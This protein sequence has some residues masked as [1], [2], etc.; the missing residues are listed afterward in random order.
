MTKSASRGAHSPVRGH[1]SGSKVVPLNSWGRVSYT[2]PIAA[3][4][5]AHCVSQQQYADDTQLYIA[6]SPNDSSTSIVNLELCLNDLYYWC[7]LNGLALNPDKTDSIL[8]GTRQRANSYT[9]SQQSKSPT[10]VL[11]SRIRLKFLE[12]LLT[13]HL[14]MDSQVSDIYHIRAMRHIRHILH[15]I[16]A[17]NIHRLQRMQNTLA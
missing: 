6:L 8:L 14:T 13:S 2:S 4:A 10:P 17:K 16:S 3:I 9:I 5:S 15:G 7:C 11:Y 12:L 1:P